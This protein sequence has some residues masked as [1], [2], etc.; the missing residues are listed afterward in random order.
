MM[1]LFRMFDVPC[2]YRG[3]LVADISKMPHPDT[4][5]TRVELK[6]NSLPF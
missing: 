4:R 6:E 2:S 3:E 5:E 1:H